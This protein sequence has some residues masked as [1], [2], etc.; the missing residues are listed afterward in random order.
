MTTIDLESPHSLETRR[1]F[2]VALFYCCMRLFPTLASYFP[3]SVSL[4]CFLFFFILSHF[5]LE[6][7]RH[8]FSIISLCC[9][10]SWEV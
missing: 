8:T 10:I 2:H 4:F 1:G 9:E 6:D 5:I 7:I 3:T